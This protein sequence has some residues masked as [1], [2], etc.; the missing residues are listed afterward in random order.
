MKKQKIVKPF[1]FNT[2]TNEIIDLLNTHYPVGI[3]YNEDLVNRIHSRY[4]LISKYEISLIVTAVFSSF[5]ELLLLGK[6][7]N[8]NNLFFDTKL[9]F[10]DKHR[11]GHII[12]SL[13]VQMSTPPKMRKNDRRRR[14]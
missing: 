11:R 13:K 4:P 7:L 6:V 12:P 9:L 10:F 5:R 8:F 14:Q 3:R 1:F 2:D